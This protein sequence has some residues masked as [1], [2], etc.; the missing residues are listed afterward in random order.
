MYKYKF[1]IKKNYKMITNYI[2][3]E[4]M[5][6]IQQY[7]EKLIGQLASCYKISFRVKGIINQHI[8][9]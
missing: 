7:S 2:R 5:T 6:Q 9:I 4:N 3:K 1:S 8:F